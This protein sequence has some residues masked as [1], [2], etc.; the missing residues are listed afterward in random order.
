M[1]SVVNAFTNPVMHV[2]PRLPNAIL[3][4]M[5]G[6]LILII[7]KQVIKGAFKVVRPTKAVKQMVL[8]I[9]N[10]ILWV[11]LLAS[12]FQSLGLPQVALALSG[13]V[14]IFGILLASGAN[15]LV[16]DIL[17]GLFLAKDPDFQ[18]GEKIKSTDF[19]GIVEHIDLRKVRVRNKDGNLHII[20]NS[21]LD[22]AQFIVLD[23]SKK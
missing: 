4:F 19:E 23:D 1:E 9:V 5:V 11:I 8:A 12:V 13:S 10:V 22:K 21:L 17:S 2:L 6:Y 7:L 3:A 14:A 15:F 16:S 20:P 18:I